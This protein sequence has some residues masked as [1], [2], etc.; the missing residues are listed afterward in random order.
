MC[1]IL[2]AVDAHAD[3]KLI[4][5][6]N[7]DEFYVRPTAAADFWTDYPDIL[8]GRDRMAG[9][10]WLGISKGGKLA[11]ITNYREGKKEKANTP[12][13][14]QLVADFLVSRGSPEAY[15][16]G[17]LSAAPAYNG[18]NLIFGS[19]NGLFY[20]SNRSE[21][22]QKITPGVHGISNHLLNTPW[23]KLQKGK[24][25]F[26]KILAEKQ[27]RPEHL[28]ELLADPV[29]AEDALLPD[30]GVGLELERILSPIFIASPGY[31]TRSST[32]LM[33]DRR[34]Q[35]TFIEKTFGHGDS[36]SVHYNFK[37]EN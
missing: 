28:F 8:G 5:A 29:H 3:Y 37:I 20:F 23:P 30:T 9:G 10:T 21:Y 15:L 13:R 14:G 26:L 16:E 24:D 22:F 33:A 18:F 35:A 12:S 6:A 17:L 32:V 2:L 25:G 27:V 7:R 31:G 4:L 11:A 36:R 34:N 19:V 1:L